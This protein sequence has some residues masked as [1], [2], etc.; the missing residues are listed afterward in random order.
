MNLNHKN[1]LEDM[2]DI[3]GIREKNLSEKVIERVERAEKRVN[4]WS[5]SDR[6]MSPGELACLINILTDKECV[7]VSKPKNVSSGGK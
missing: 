5:G 7:D 4:A 6:E 3:R 1:M 2:L